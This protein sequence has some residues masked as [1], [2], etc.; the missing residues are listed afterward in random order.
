MRV[1]VVMGVTVLLH[2]GAD[3]LSLLS[4]AVLLLVLLLLL[5]SLLCVA[6]LHCGGR[7]LV[8]Q[9]GGPTIVAQVNER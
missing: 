7:S 4:L 8:S 3:A 9:Q 1:R 5:L 6:S 2:A